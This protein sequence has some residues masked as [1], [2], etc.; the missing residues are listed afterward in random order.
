M[1]VIS[2]VLVGRRGE[3]AMVREAVDAAGRGQGSAQFVIG[4]PGIGKSRLAAEA[5]THGVRVVRG[6]AGG[7]PLRAIA[8]AVF[9]AVRGYDIGADRLGPYWPVLSRLAPAG[10]ASTAPA[11]PDPLVVRAEAMLRLLTET[12]TPAGCIL[13][14]EDLHDAD[15]D[16]LAVVDYL[17]DNLADQPV[18]LLATLR[19]D[20]GPALD[21]AVQAAA[22]RAARVLRLNPL[23]PA[24]TAELAARCLGGEPPAAVVECLREADGNPFVIEEL[25]G[26]LVEGGDLVST[27]DAWTV[28]GTVRARVPATV[29]AA[30]LRQVDRLDPDGV[31]LLEAAAILGRRFPLR[32]AAEVA[33]L[34]VPLALRHLRQ[35]SQWQLVGP[36]TDADAGPAGPAAPGAVALVPATPANDPDRYAFRHALTAAAILSRL[37][38]GERVALSRAA[39]GAVGDTDPVLAA[40]LWSAAAE[41]EQAAVRYTAAG[42]DAAARGALATAVDLLERGLAGLD[43]GTADPAILTDLLDE[44]LRALV[45]TGD[46]GRVFALGSRL[47]S[48]LNAAGAPVSRRVAV[49]VAR[50]RASVTAGEWERGLA[51]VDAA[52]ALAGDRAD[53]ALTAP[54]DAVAAHL[55]LGSSRPGRLAH[56]ESL[57]ML[58]V[59]A[60]ESVPLPD[61]ACEALEVLARCGRRGDH[62]AATAY[63]DR[64]L[65]IAAENGLVI[66]QIRGLLELGVIDKYRLGRPG[67]LLDAQRAARDSGAVITLA[68]I[69]LHLANTYIHTGEFDLATVCNERAAGVAHRFGLRELELLT[70]GMEAGIA[71]GRGRGD[72]VEQ[73]LARLDGA[74]PL[75]YGDEVW[76]HVRGMCALL[77]EDREQAMADFAGAEAA[78]GDGAAIRGSGYA[79]PY[80]LLR[81]VSGDAGWPEYLTFEGSPMAWLALHRPYLAWSRAVLLGRAGRTE[82]A[83][84]AARMAISTSQDLPTPRHLGA[85][86]VAECALAD[87]WGEPLLWLREAEEHFHGVGVARVAAACRALLRQSGAHPGQRRTGHDGIP[88]TLRGEGVTVREFEVL[89][90]LAERLGNIEIAERLFLSPRTVERHVASLRA[91]TGQ[92]DRAHLIAYARQRITENPPGR[93]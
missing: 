6:R 32:I 19:P 43:A 52:R 30:V 60:A 56:A 91:R 36:D 22:R 83:A 85:R 7:V 40:E 88:A 27:G 45:L 87:G 44:L 86:L 15:A 51:E 38:P 55:M 84:E 17:V 70:A 63:L 4:E 5:P 69:D 12:G 33:G 3:L 74:R 68:W 46:T 66:W 11:G 29:A 10:L 9:S 61:V 39:A 37:L 20:P 1:A 35:A 92:P 31:A 75:G 57:A 18:L 76:G 53:P 24:E 58:A 71:A 62:L 13:L 14:L 28:R 41:P 80:L 49:H 8:E 79:G 65:L 90:L 48:A 16:T 47:E 2:P 34:T 26:A 78:D 59:D 72:L 73:A 21:L 93:G 50:A 82:E 64:L 54:I 25:L 77:A 89:R 81:V 42:R 23:D 67:R